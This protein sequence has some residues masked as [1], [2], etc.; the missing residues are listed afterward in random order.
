MH[1][2]LSKNFINDENY[3]QQY[4]DIQ[5]I[6]NYNKQYIKDK[7]DDYLIYEKDPYF[8][9]SL[10]KGSFNKKSLDNIKHEF[11]QVYG[12]QYLQLL[13]NLEKLDL[14]KKNNQ[15]QNIIKDGEYYPTSIDLLKKKY[16]NNIYRWCY[17]L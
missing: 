5:E 4:N 9:V 7:I 14:F 8:I 6:F 17:F 12:H 10:Y 3:I 1:I 15:Y 13:I 16:T 2:E 11:L